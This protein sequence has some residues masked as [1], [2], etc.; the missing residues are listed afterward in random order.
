M[1]LKNAE[2]L[3]A[4]WYAGKTTPKQERELKRLMQEPNLPEDLIPDRELIFALNEASKTELPDSEFDKK[5]LEVIDE[6]EETRIESKFNLRMLAAAA[7]L[8]TALTFLTIWFVN[9]QDEVL[10]QTAYTEEEI[11]YAEEITDSTL[12]L[13]S[14]LLKTGTGELSRI[15]VV[16]ANL[17]KLEYL[18]AVNHGIKQ[19]ETI[20]K[21]NKQHSKQENES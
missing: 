15:A 14:S 8:I 7:V 13:I 11:Q 4:K 6:Y 10:I 5:V 18:S 9:K 21:T 17:E 16:R 1:D 3:L 19:L 12:L 20:P 2:Q